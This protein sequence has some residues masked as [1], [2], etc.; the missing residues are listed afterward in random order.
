MKTFE[1]KRKSVLE[2]CH[3]ALPPGTQG[4]AIYEGMTLQW[5]HNIFFGTDMIRLFGVNDW[6]YVHEEMDEYTTEHAYR[7]LNLSVRDA[8]AAERGEST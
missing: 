1:E 4:Q 7:L 5:I 2:C 6:L 8:L 3:L